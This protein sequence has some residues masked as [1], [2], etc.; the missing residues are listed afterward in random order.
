MGELETVLQTLDEHVASNPT[1]AK[2]LAN[3]IIPDLKHAK[4]Y[5]SVVSHLTE[6]IRIIDGKASG[7]VK[8]EAHRA[9]GAFLSANVV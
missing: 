4:K 8:T 1:L 9:Y 2:Q 3:K 6:M 7:N 5:S